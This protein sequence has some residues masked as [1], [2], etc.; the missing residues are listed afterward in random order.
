MKQFVHLINFFFK[1]RIEVD[2]KRKEEV[3]NYR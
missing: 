1:T 3:M 2:P